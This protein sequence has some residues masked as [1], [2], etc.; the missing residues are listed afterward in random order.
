[1]AAAITDAF[2]SDFDERFEDGLT[3]VLGGAKAW[4][5]AGGRRRRRGRRL[6]ER[7]WLAAGPEPG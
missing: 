1:L 2:T 7:R 3:I 5:N 4:L 6:A